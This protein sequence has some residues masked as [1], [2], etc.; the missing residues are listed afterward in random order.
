[1]LHFSCYFSYFTQHTASSSVSYQVLFRIKIICIFLPLTSFNR[2]SSIFGV[3]L[4]TR[5]KQ[6]NNTTHPYTIRQGHIHTSSILLLLLSPSLSPFHGLG[7]NVI[8]LHLP[9]FSN[10]RFPRRV[11]TKQHTA[12][13]QSVSHQPNK[14][15]LCQP[16]SPSFPTCHQPTVISGVAHTRPPEGTQTL[17][18]TSIKRRFVDESQ[19]ARKHSLFGSGSKSFSV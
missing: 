11:T 15:T 17:T 2:L 1:M 14:T 18:H 4:L 16:N 5:R 12:R 6:H 3:A 10:F 19:C 9:F 7:L 8:I 13:S